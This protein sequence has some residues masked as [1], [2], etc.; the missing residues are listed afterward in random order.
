MAASRPWRS[1]AA[2]SIQRQSSPSVT[3]HAD[4]ARRRR[5]RAQQLG[6]ADDGRRLL[7]QQ[8]GRGALWLMRVVD[9]RLVTG[10]GQRSGLRWLRRRGRGRRCRRARRRPARPGRAPCSSRKPGEL[11]AL[12]AG[13]AQGGDDVER[14]GPARASPGGKPAAPPRSRRDRP[15]RWAAAHRSSRSADDRSDVGLRR[16]RRAPA[17]PTIVAAA[18]A[19]SRWASRP[20]DRRS[21]RSRRVDVVD[22]VGFDRDGVAGVEEAEALRARRSGGPPAGRPPGRGPG[23]PGRP[24]RARAPPGRAR[25]TVSRNRHDRALP[26]STTS[27][28]ASTRGRASSRRRR[29][30]SAADGRGEPV[31]QVRGRA[32]CA[33]PGRRPRAPRRGRRLRGGR[34][35]SATSSPVDRQ[36]AAGGVRRRPRRGRRR[37]AGRAATL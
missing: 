11:P 29:S 17:G 1:R 22:V 21:A 35:A 13:V 34:A 5:D 25:P 12:G 23:A 15:A 26:R 28:K 6:V 27:R 16:R 32:G 2:T 9:R 19:G 20:S 18:A 30:A 33:R 24:R 36:P 10:Q 37:A 4:R 8:V 14:C 31:E 3:V 7:V